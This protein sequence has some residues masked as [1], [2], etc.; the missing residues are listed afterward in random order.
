MGRGGTKRILSRIGAIAVAIALFLVLRHFLFDAFRIPSASMRPT[1]REGDYLFARK[2][3]A[4]D[5]GR[6]ALVIFASPLDPDVAV[7]KRVVAVAGDTVAM[8]A[9]RLAVNGVEL[10]EPYVVPP[11]PG[12]DPEDPQMRAWQ[13]RYLAAGDPAAYRPTL[14]TWG[15]L[16][17]PPDSVFVLG[18]NR[19]HSYDSRYW[20]W[21]GRDRIE[22]RPVIIYYSYDPTAEGRLAV[23]TAIRWQRLLNRPR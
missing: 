4:Q 10:T 18:D 9:G 20:G 21:L 7:V 6:G 12:V 22:G 11:E 15:P 3:G 17:V 8:A 23:V 2:P 5:A 19:D 1:L 13:R 14:R 16:V